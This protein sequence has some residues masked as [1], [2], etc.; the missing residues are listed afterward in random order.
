V[1][2]I[3]HVLDVVANH[4]IER[5][6]GWACVSL[7]AELRFG[8]RLNV[9][10]E[11][12]IGRLNDPVADFNERG[13]KNAGKLAYVARPTVLQKAGQGAGTKKRRSLLVTPAKTF[14]QEV[15]DPEES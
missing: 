15:G 13:F 6:I 2:E 12:H 7:P 8:G 11:D 4:G 5:E 3:E 14:Q 10:D 1:I 9:V